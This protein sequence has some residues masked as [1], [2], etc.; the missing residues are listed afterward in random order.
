MLKIKIFSLLLGLSIS[1]EGF[2]G[3]CDPNTGEECN[4][5]IDIIANEVACA[6]KFA[7]KVHSFPTDHEK[8]GLES[9]I[10]ETMMQYQGLK[11]VMPVELLNQVF[12]ETYST[13]YADHN[14]AF[15]VFATRQMFAICVNGFESWK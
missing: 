10:F 3:V 12:K 11:D 8:K 15:K 1:I 6:L 13:Y 14:D 5:D 2:S 9:P 4:P 7:N